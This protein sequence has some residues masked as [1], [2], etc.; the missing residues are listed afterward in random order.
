VLAFTDND[1]VADAGWLRSLISCLCEP[2]TEMAGG[3]VLSP[4]PDGLVAA[5]EAARSPLD[6]GDASGPVGPAGPIAYIPSCNL[7]ADRETLRR[8]GGFDESMALGEDAD[9]VWRASRAGCGVRY[10]PAAKIVH[11]HRTRLAA[12]LRRR[13]DYGSSEADLQLRHPEAR[14]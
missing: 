5:F 6:M 13:A 2:G 9:L 4:P 10:E 3:R 1:C 14:G 11:R 12:L 8:L 7:A